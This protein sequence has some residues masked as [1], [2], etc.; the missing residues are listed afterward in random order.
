MTVLAEFA[1]D[2]EIAALG[3]VSY[4]RVES[5]G[6]QVHFA[7]EGGLRVDAVRV[8]PALVSGIG[9]VEVRVRQVLVRARRLGQFIP[10]RGV[11]TTAASR[12][13][14]PFSPSMAFAFMAGPPIWSA[15]PAVQRSSRGSSPMLLR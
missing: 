3:E 8:L 6:V 7:V 9:P 14:V 12:A 5:R 15:T 1:G 2:S 13:S 10:V 4:R 11:P